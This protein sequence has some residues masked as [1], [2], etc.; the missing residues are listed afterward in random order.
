MQLLARSST[1][2]GLH[3]GL[4]LIDAVVER[5]DVAESRD[6]AHKKLTLPH[7]GWNAAKAKAGSRLFEG[8]PTG[9]DFYFVHSYAVKANRDEDV[10]ATCEY[11]HEFAAAIESGNVLAT[12]F[13]P[14]KSHKD[15]Y[16]LI[17]N[18][19]RICAAGRVAA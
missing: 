7:I 12:Q 8:I 15:G 14:E 11:G 3:D 19:L 5:M 9:A 13:H 16:R 2:G 17:E 4:G 6:W 10:A 18:Y 1:E